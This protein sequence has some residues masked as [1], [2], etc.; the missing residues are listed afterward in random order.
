MWLTSYGRASGF[1]VDPIEKKPLNHFHPGSRVLSFGATGCN[2]A[3]R[4]CQ[5]WDISKSRDLDRLLQAATPEQVADLALSHRCRSVAFT[6]TDPATFIEYVVDCAQVCHERGIATVAVSAGY[7]YPEAADLLFSQMDAANIDL[8]AFRDGFYHKLCAGRLAPVLDTL[9]RIRHR[10]DTWLELTTLLIPGHNDD[11]REIEA[12]CEWV[13]S[14]L[15]ADT[16]LHFTAFHPDWRMR[17][18][19]PTPPA[20]LRRARTI[21]RACG[22]RYVYVGNV[23][24]MEGAT[25]FCPGC[26][27]ALIVRDG[28]RIKENRLTTERACSDCGCAVAGIW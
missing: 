26:G 24:D 4:F 28:Y 27:K 3:C 9:E 22:L 15:G 18:V 1:A 14:H 25:T 12:M 23:R 17:D 16:P 21:A 10:H 7:L 5:N 13:V 11:D 6:Y 19:P 20:T 8:K 2:L